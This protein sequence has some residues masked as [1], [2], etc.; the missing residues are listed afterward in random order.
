MDKDR[1][2]KTKGIVKNYF[3]GIISA[4]MLRPQVCEECRACFKS[5]KKRLRL[6]A[7]EQFKPGDDIIIELSCQTVYRLSIL[8]GFF[9]A[10]AG[11]AGFWLGYSIKGTLGGI[12]GAVIFLA[13]VFN[14]IN[15]VIKEKYSDSVSI[16]KI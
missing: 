10:V 11:I 13:V 3:K 1:I 8:S 7:A 15:K 16:I 12:V 5:K 14:G 4:I 9:P 6:P 2:I